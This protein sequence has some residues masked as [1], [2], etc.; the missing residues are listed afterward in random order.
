MKVR[1][2]RENGS[3]RQVALL[4]VVAGCLWLDLAAAQ[5]VAGVLTGS[6]GALSIAGPFLML[7]NP[8][9]PGAAFPGLASPAWAYWA[10]CVALATL[11]VVPVVLLGRQRPAAPV[12]AEGCAARAHVAAAAGG[13]PLL[14]RAT[15]LRP[16]LTNVT[17]ADLGYRLGVSRG[18]GCHASVED[19]IVLLGPPRSGKGLHLVIPMILDAPGPV[20][21]TSTR[22]DNLAVT[23]GRRAERGPV[24]VFDPQQLAPGVPSA[25]R[26]SPIRGCQ[27]PHIAMVRARALTA[28][29]GAGTTD[30][31]FWQASA[32]QAVRCLLHAAALE[33]FSTADLYRWSLSSMQA[34]EAVLVLAT[35]P[36]AAPSWDQALDA[37]INSDSRQRDSIWAMVTIAFAALADPKVL[38][39][40]SPDAGEQFEPEEFLRCSG[41]VYLLGTSTGVGA[42]AGLVGAFVEDVIEAARRVAARSPVSGWT[43]RCR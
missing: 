34:R 20:L 27:D 29:T 33:Q 41:T 16:S 40:V 7:V 32:E 19:S 15:L 37:I 36:S 8:T 5:S 26:W 22:P 13:T 18:V 28:G 10:I 24:A 14:R 38:D 35:H 9:E 25:T 3:D 39:A 12:I 6:S 21:T 31:T 2:G 23:L 1:V 4:V 17:P 11:L 42:T 30:S 43:R